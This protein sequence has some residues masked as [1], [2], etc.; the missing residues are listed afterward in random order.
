MATPNSKNENRRQ[1][2]I[3]DC[4]EKDNETQQK[5]NAVK[6]IYCQNLETAGDEIETLKIG[7]DANEKIYK[8]KER[9]YLSTRENFQRYINTEISMG[10]QLVQSNEKMKT[11][12]ASYKTWDDSL[13]AQVT[14]IFK[15]VKDVKTKMGDLREAAGKL[16]NSKS[17]SCSSSQ[18]CIITGKSDCKDD[19]QQTVETEGCKD[20][21]KVIELLFEMPNALSVDID[22]IF[23]SSSDIIG[24]QKFCNTGSLVVLQ[25]SLYTNAKAFDKFLMDTITLRKTDLD[26]RMLE[27]KAALADRTASVMDI[28]SQRCNYA[29]IHSTLKKICCPKCGCVQSTDDCKP[30]LEECAEDICD[31]CGEVKFAFIKEEAPAPPAPA[32]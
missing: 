22:A 5:I 6:K 12:I 10:S 20:I 23:K 27:L 3:P 8:S 29:G 15:T 28:Y 31:I 1:A 13:A 9:R 25:D 24:I 11:S 7:Y 26:A 19:T 32:A 21:E 18:W 16:E 17:D 4:I 14:L 2:D 30:R